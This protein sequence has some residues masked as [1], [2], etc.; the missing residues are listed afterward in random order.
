MEMINSQE[1][2][3][4]LFEKKEQNRTRAEQTE[5]F[6]NLAI[7]NL[8]QWIIEDIERE[9]MSIGDIGCAEGIGTEILATH[10]KNSNVIGIDFSDQAIQVARKTHPKCNFEVGDICN[11]KKDFDVLFTSNVLEHFYY[12]GQVFKGMITHAKKYCI[13]LVPFREYYTVPEHFSYFDFQSFPLHIED[14]YELC[15][16][17]PINIVG[18]NTKYWYGEQMLVVYGKKDHVAPL[19]LTLRNLYNGYVEERTQLIKDYDRKIEALEGQV[20]DL[21]LGENEKELLQQT[22]SSN[23]ELTLQLKKIN[24]KYV[25]LLEDQANYLKNIENYKDVIQKKDIQISG[26]AK[27]LEETN[28]EFE[29][30]KSELN[31][32]KTQNSN[33]EEEYNKLIPYKRYSEDVRKQ[34]Q[35]VYEDIVITQN[36]R[37]YKFSL[38]LRR[39]VEQCIRHK[40]ATDF[41]KWFGG[42]VFHKKNLI[43]KWLCQYDYLEDAKS[44][45]DFLTQY[46]E[47]ASDVHLMEVESQRKF[48]QIFIFASVPYFD[49][50]GGQRS[51]QLAKTFNNM[52]YAVYYIYGFPC[53]EKDIPDMDIPVLKHEYIDDIDEIWFKQYVKKDAVVIF[54]IPYIKFKPYLDMANKYG[55]HTIYEH[56]DNWDSSLGNMFYDKDIFIHFLE[57]AQKITVTAKLLGEKVSEYVK[58][59]YLYSANAVNTE[60]FEPTKQYEKPGDLVIGKEKTLLYFGSLWGKWFD[61]EKIDYIAE[62]CPECTINLIGDNSGIP[63]RVKNAAPNIHFLGLKKQT[64]LPAYLAY[65]D[66]ALLPFKN[67]EIGKYVSPLKIFEYIAMNKKVISTP[68]DDIALYPNVFCSD[69]KDEWVQEIH[70]GINVIDSSQFISCNNWYARCNQMLSLFFEP[71]FADINI[72]IVVLNYNNLKVIGKCIDSLITHNRYNYEIIVVDN[73]SKDGSYEMLKEKYDSKICLLQNDRN[74]CSS[75]RNLGVAHAKGDWI[76]F[77]DSDQ[78][79]ISDSWLDCALNILNDKVTIGAISW[80]AGWFEPGKTTGPIVDYLP[81]RAISDHSLLYRTDIAYLATSG[82]IMKKKIFDEIKGFDEFYDPTCFEDT[83]LSLKIRHEGYDI[84]YSPYMAIMHLP[85]QTTKSGSSTHTK[86]MNRNGEYFK[87]KWEKIDKSL[88]EYYLK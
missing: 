14:E 5:F 64:T 55:C 34:S 23:E 15:Y 12:S 42:K 13:I 16:F 29:K 79:I 56:I 62:K 58:R 9:N 11:L 43:T 54:E 39:F 17:K 45:L 88:L 85:H 50:G 77:L 68:L 44:Q 1:Y 80:N 40:E 47:E 10:F 22:V 66:I 67:C 73:G 35:R 30:T 87:S 81:N 21:K 25:G 53:S 6:V 33:W 41:I 75:G 74:G 83:D 7:A 28:S 84:A 26:I 70:R 20:N 49:V 31:N 72:S 46:P 52:G 61:W 37:S 32:A 57:S 19:N 76:V 2:W 48:G 3:N 4:E 51:A 24:E 8:P 60:L 36:S 63:E 69:D 59:D 78:W 86:L 82:L 18:E 71:K 27:K 65:A 38:I